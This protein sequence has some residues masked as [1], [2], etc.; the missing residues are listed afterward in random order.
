MISLKSTLHA[1]DALLD[2]CVQMALQIIEEGR[3]PMSPQQIQTKY[4][5]EFPFTVKRVVGVSVLQ[6]YNE[7]AINITGV[8]SV[9][10]LAHKT[11]EGNYK[12]S[13]MEVDVLPDSERFVWIGEP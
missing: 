8:G 13:D 11:L 6:G 5:L 2:C 7:D 12:I 9:L 4:Q 3:K 1:T 10:V